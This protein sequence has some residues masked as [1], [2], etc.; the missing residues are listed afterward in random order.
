MQQIL[1]VEFACAKPGRIA[2]RGDDLARN[3]AVRAEIVLGFEMPALEVEISV[4]DELTVDLFCRKRFEIAE[5]GF[6]AVGPGRGCEARVQN[7]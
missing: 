2:V 1:V 6:V 4:L 3:Q 7:L 5:H